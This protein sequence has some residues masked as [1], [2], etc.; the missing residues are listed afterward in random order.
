MMQ[1]GRVD[2]F[3]VFDFKTGTEFSI[4]ELIIKKQDFSYHDTSSSFLFITLM[5]GSNVL[6]IGSPNA[7]K[8]MYKRTQ[9]TTKQVTHSSLML[10]SSPK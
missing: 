1:T 6:P 5:R 3:S 4:W 9:K 2:L 10:P 8:N 7:L